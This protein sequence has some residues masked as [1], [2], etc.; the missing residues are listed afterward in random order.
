MMR[1]VL[2][3]GLFCVGLTSSAAHAGSGPW[4]IGPG[5]GSLYLGL[6]SQRITRLAITVDGERDV[7]DVG[8]GISSFGLKAIGTLGITSRIE[9]EAQLPWSS[10]QANRPDDAI[11]TALGLNA[12]DKTQTVGVIDARGKVLAL[13]EYFGAPLSLAI[14]G[15]VRYGAFTA[16]TR[17]R[18]T[19]AGEGTTDV[20]PFLSVGR[21]T[22]PGG[23][24]VL[25]VYGTVGW[26]YRF[27]TT[28]AYPDP[29]S[30]GVSA[31]LPETWADV[32][33]L[34]GPNARFVIGPTASMLYRPGLDWGELDLGDPD[35][36]AALGVTTARMGGT[37]VVNNG[38]D[39][40]LSVNVLGTLY[41]RNNP[42][43]VLSVNVGLAYRGSR[44]P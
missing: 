5:Q 36:L 22:S 9:V 21:V 42:T 10:N 44:K 26:R 38:S 27:P 19:N 1:N 12:C 23:G 24:S 33:L 6:E 20:G 14:G 8:Q 15:E 13:D 16:D 3:T 7:I 18:I 28:R 37:A 39:L 32:E 11:C 31:P 40:S 25:S 35:R 29:S 2:A 4:V 17:A 41:A 43:D 30:D 34:S